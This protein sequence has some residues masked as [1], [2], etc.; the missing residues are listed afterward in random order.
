MFMKNAQFILV[1]SFNVIIGL[2]GGGSGVSV[3]NLTAYEV[4]SVPPEFDPGK[5]LWDTE[6]HEWSLN[7]EYETQIAAGKIYWINIGWVDPD[8]NPYA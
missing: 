4:T 8:Y 6:T 5:Y 1:D 3:P 2:V 7:P